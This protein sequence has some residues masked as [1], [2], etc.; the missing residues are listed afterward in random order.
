MRSLVSSAV[1][2]ALANA[3]SIPIYG[4]YP[5]YVQGSGATGITVEV[6][7]DYLCSDCYNLNPVLEDVLTQEWLGGT[8]ADQI[9][10]AITPFPLPYH[11]HSYQVAEL[12]PYFMDLAIETSNSVSLSNAYRDLSFE[13]LSTILSMKDTSLNDFVTW[14]SATV[15]TELNL[16]AGQVA[17]AYSSS[18]YSVDSNSRDFLKYSWAKGVYGTPAAFIN[19]VRLDNVPTTTLGWM[20][21]LKAVYA[22]Q[23]KASTQ[24]VYPQ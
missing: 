18:T 16:P 8:V 9:A 13:Y 24:G 7:M 12:V 14:W 4:T 11:V 15:E 6:F 10:L 19:G 3:N 20:A 17:A 5:G 21:Q 22:S 23:F 2:A 1:L